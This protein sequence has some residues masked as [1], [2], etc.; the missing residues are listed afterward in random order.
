MIIIGFLVLANSQEKRGQS[1]PIGQ[2]VDEESE[3][4]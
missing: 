2:V 3:P 1:M 4:V